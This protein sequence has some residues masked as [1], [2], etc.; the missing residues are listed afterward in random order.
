M[1][2]DDSLSETIENASPEFTVGTILSIP[3]S[4]LN[5][6]GFIQQLKFIVDEIVTDE[7]SLSLSYAGPTI[8]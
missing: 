1:N 8:P 2:I 6:H 4:H 3:T 5:N 7:T